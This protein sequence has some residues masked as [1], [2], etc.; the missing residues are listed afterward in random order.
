MEWF[1]PIRDFFNARGMRHYAMTVSLPEVRLLA[2]PVKSQAGAFA[3]P[4]PS[5][6]AL[7]EAGGVVGHLHYGFSPLRDRVY[8]Y[9][10]EIEPDQRRQGFA[11]S[12]LWNLHLQFRLP[13]VALQPTSAF[14]C[15]AGVILGRA[16]AH[17]STA[18]ES[19]ERCRWDVLP[20]ADEMLPALEEFVG[21]EEWARIL[22]AMSA[23]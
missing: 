23:V 16:G 19:L 20:V 4:A 18:H 5:C 9:K 14:W 1:D 3:Y 6:M 8:V 21:S 13:L 12:T 15:S 22:T 2:R 11:L 7:I 10:L 17:L